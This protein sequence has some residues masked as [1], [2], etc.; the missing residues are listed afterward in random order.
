MSSRKSITMLTSTND[1]IEVVGDK[2]RADGYY[3]FT[4]GKHTVQV[5]YIN[6]TGGINMQATLAIDPTEDDWFDINLN[7]LVSNDPIY[8]I[9]GETGVRAFTFT[10]NFTYLRVL[11][12]R[13]YILPVP[14]PGTELGSISKVLL[15]M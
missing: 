14:L 15:S 9:E 3:G 13:D 11:L 12:K 4:D 8:K 5:N 10:G 1:E 6:F 7:K 2:I